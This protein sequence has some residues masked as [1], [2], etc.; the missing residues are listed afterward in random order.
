M[1]NNIEKSID[2]TLQLLKKKKVKDGDVIITGSNVLSLKSENKELSEFAK[3]KTHALG[4]RIIKDNKVGI[5]FTEDLSDWAIE[6][7]ID[8]AINNSKFSKTNE[9]VR[10]E[11]QEE[12]HVDETTQSEDVDTEHLIE[13]TFYLEEE[14]KRRDER[15]KTPPY[16]GVQESES[17]FYL[18]NTH[19]ARCSYKAKNYGCYTSAL[20]NE[21]DKNS[22]HFNKR[23]SKNFNQL[24]FDELITEVVDTSKNL[25]TAN[26]IKSGEYLVKFSPDLLSSFFSAFS[27]LISGKAVMDNVSPWRDKLN[28]QVMDQRLTMIDSPDYKEALTKYPFDMEGHRRTD[29]SL[30]E[31]GILKTFLHNS[32]TSNKLKMKNNNCAFRGPKSPLGVSS[33]NIIISAS[34]TDNIDNL[35][36]VE[37][38]TAQGLHSGINRTSGE[39]SLGVSG[40]IIKNGE[41]V[42]YFK[43]STF[44]GNFFK[45]LKEVHSISDKKEASTDKSFFTPEIIFNEL[46]FAGAI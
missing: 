31:G 5:S 3:S 42:G 15:A 26:Q 2:K 4:V 19:G 18:A 6:T 34:S 40:R 25:L 13:K 45:M 32:E 41:I 43:D 27:S 46:T 21:G 23:L 38:L 29:I 37:I 44:S 22:M 14:I 17:H 33:S 12:I 1:K 36:Y 16:N 11:S 24:D 8:N 35:D 39:I 20:L 9:Y 7:T 28:E 30:V 10:I